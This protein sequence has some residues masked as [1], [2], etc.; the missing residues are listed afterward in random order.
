MK[1]VKAFLAVSV[2]CIVLIL[3]ILLQ[4][5][6]PVYAQA[7]PLYLREVQISTG[8]T[9]KEAKQWLID[10]GYTVLNEDL[11]AGTGED[12]AYLGYKTTTDRSLAICDINMVSMQSGYKTMNY[13]ELLKQTIESSGDVFDGILVILAEFRANYKAGSPNAR[14]AKESLDVLMYDEGS[15]QTLGDYLLDPNRTADEVAELLLMC[16]TLV[17]SLIYNQ[18]VVGVSDYR[19]DGTTWLDRISQAE[20]LPEKLTP[21]E[22]DDL[23]DLYSEKAKKLDRVITDYVTNLYDAIDR[24]DKNGDGEVNEEDYILDNENTQEEADKYLEQMFNGES[25]SSTNADALLLAT[26]DYLC[27]FDYD[28]ISVGELFE[29][30]ASSGDLRLLYPLVES[31][32]GLTEGQIN[33]MQICGVANMTICTVN[34]EENYQTTHQELVTRSDELVRANN[35]QKPTAFVGVNK[36]VYK[37]EVGLTTEAERYASSTGN[38]EKLTEED[39][40][41]GELK[42]ALMVCGV[43][44]LAG[45]GLSIVGMGLV[46]GSLLSFGFF[47][48]L[49]AVAAS[50]F[51][52][53][54]SFFSALGI[55]VPFAAGALAVV[56]I[57]V[58]LVIL[59]IDVIKDAYNDKHPQYTEIPS[60]M[61]DYDVKTSEFV[62]YEAVKERA[63]APGDVNCFQ[64]RR[65]N[66]LYVSYDPTAGSPITANSM[67]EF[68]RV[69]R[70]NSET[71]D[72]TYVGV[73]Y[74]GQK[75]V[76]N[77]N[78]YTYKDKVK[79]LYLFFTTEDS[80][81]GITSDRENGRYLQSI[82]IA[83]AKSPEEAKLS[84]T[85]MT[86]FE[87]LE[88]DLTPELATKYTYI[89]YRT[90]SNPNDA[91]TDI[92][93]HVAVPHKGD[94]GLMT[95]P[96]IKYGNG[97][98]S[99][100]CA[101]VYSYDYYGGTQEGVMLYYTKQASCG[102]PILADFYTSR[103]YQDVPTGYEPINYFCGGPAV[104]LAMR[105]GYS[106]YSNEEKDCPK[107]FVYFR[108]E[109][110]YEGE[111]IY[112]GGLAVMEMLKDTKQYRTMDEMAYE[113][114]WQPISVDLKKVD[115]KYQGWG[116][117]RLCY[118][119][120][121]NP[122]RAIYDI[123]T[124]T[125]EPKAGSTMSNINFSGAGYMILDGYEM[126][127]GHYYLRLNHN[128]LIDSDAYDN[129]NRFN[130]AD[131]RGKIP[132]LVYAGCSRGYVTVNKKKPNAMGIY[133][134][135]PMIDPEGKTTIEP[136][137]V[138]EFYVGPK[139]GAPSGLSA[140]VDF[141]DYY[142]ERPVPISGKRDIYIYYNETYPKKLQYIESIEVVYSNTKNFSH[143]EAKLTLLAQ[144]GHEILDFNLAS[145]NGSTMFEDIQYGGSYMSQ[146]D[147]R[148]AFIRVKR[149]EKKAYAIEDIR[150]YEVGANDPEP[151][152]TIKING[153]TYTRASNRIQSYRVP[154]VQ[155]T[156]NMPRQA[157]VRPYYFYIYYSTGNGAAVSDISIDGT[158]MQK[159]QFTVLDTNGKTNVQNP[160]W[161]HMTSPEL[162]EMKYFKNVGVGSAA[163]YSDYD[164]RNLYTGQK[165]N[166]KNGLYC[167]L[168]N[169]G[170]SFYFLYDFNNDTSKG[171]S[172]YIGYNL[173][174]DSQNC[175][176]NM[177]TSEK[178]SSTITV[179][180][181]KYTL[182]S[183]IS[184]N[185]SLKNGN[186]IYL[187]YSTDTR[188]GKPIISFNGSQTPL[189]G[190]ETMQRVEGGNSN[191]NLNAADKD[192]DCDGTYTLMPHYL[193][194]FR[195]GGK[196]VPTVKVVASAFSD[197]PQLT[198]VVVMAGVTVLVAAGAI[199]IKKRKR[200]NS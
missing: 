59:L 45:I 144:E 154:T 180:G 74:F 150:I 97:S 189:N 17:S 164:A 25:V 51:L 39:P 30:F 27:M 14:I 83:Q 4:T 142:G 42:N 111:K 133:V 104:N 118:T 15:D 198:M 82:V 145:V 137:R 96:T 132:T 112:L 12:Y 72:N 50:A 2:M 126:K 89:G 43:I 78:N 54:S 125:A 183:N 16:N 93:V 174:K 47:A 35:G 130:V 176:R 161:I 95:G 103:D 5:V 168:L 182:G 23:D 151:P 194:L 67:G 193:I 146:Y 36:E 101:G 63:G 107:A 173:T 34:T 7:Q 44:A 88:F 155:I 100:T 196:T 69:K 21:K 84:I 87:V 62:R 58:I 76:T 143:D 90:T 85:R 170:F 169:R 81:A 109:K 127:N 98:A 116:G 86:G 66:A 28:D 38:Y 172:V 165:P 49:T 148:A 131:E 79:G 157:V 24:L 61:F 190:Y 195:E 46:V 175:V 19:E 94:D 60:V 128:L 134:C 163:D 10:N 29:N 70:G 110:P 141:T 156:A 11:N 162:K 117:L 197:S 115:S 149:T 139:S 64:A 200:K 57:V 9:A 92:R 186:T 147:D 166:A 53:L 135:G 37:T 158:A 153:Y 114:G 41:R 99:Y 113:L 178:C 20:P 1:K 124:Y 138:S 77:L 123:R 73:G 177:I 71:A 8:K 187:Y 184:F 136:I 121:N 191:L 22:L 48:C 26:Y 6:L 119:A 65:W 68:F 179:S 75:A 52:T 105:S 55:L 188:C 152:K 91:I 31:S 33:A 171:N 32:T 129:A 199:L 122:K 140:V 56:A 159:N 3:T 192:P 167:D 181:I 120:T 106:L 185:H 108:Y 13:G 160:W 40:L 18:L 80:L 102:D